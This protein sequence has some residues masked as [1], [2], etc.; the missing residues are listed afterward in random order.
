MPRPFLRL[1]RGPWKD[2]T[3]H[4]S[5]E[6]EQS[7]RFDS[8]TVGCTGSGY[9]Y[10]GIHLPRPTARGACHPVTVRPTLLIVNAAGKKGVGGLRSS[11]RRRPSRRWHEVTGLKGNRCKGPFGFCVEAPGHRTSNFCHPS[12]IGGRPYRRI[13]APESDAAW[14]EAV[15]LM[16]GKKYG[17]YEYVLTLLG[18]G[19]PFDSCAS[20]PSGRP[21]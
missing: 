20:T 6:I 7:L 17:T 5:D 2:W 1:I 15:A 18:R 8:G 4:S 19:T 11:C 16:I 13:M 3:G 14:G 9:V 10:E 12:K 21:S